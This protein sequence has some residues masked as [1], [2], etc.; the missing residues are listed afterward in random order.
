MRSQAPILALV[1]VVLLGGGFFFLFG[2][3]PQTPIDAGGSREPIAEEPTRDDTS[4]DLVGVQGSNDDLDRA[5][6]DA[7]L[8]ADEV[9]VEGAHPWAGQ[10]A[11]VTGRIVEEDGAP[12]VGMRVE[13]LEIDLSNIMKVEH[14]AMG[15]DAPELGEAFTDEE[16]RFLIDGARRNAYHAFNIGRGT[17]RAT[18]RF[19]ENALEHGELTDVGDIV[20]PAYGT[21]VGTVIDEDGEPVGGARV[22]ALPIP[23]MIVQSGVLD[24]REGSVVAGGEDDDRKMAFD[25]PRR[26]FQLYE[27]LPVPTTYSA[28]DGTFRLE[29]V[30][31]G[32]ISGGADY[33]KHVG[34]P[35]GPIE[36]SAG[37]E[38]DVGELELLFGREVTGKVTDGAGRPVAGVEVAAGALNPLFPA[39]LMQPAGVTDDLGNYSIEGIPEEGRL[40]G[41]ARRTKSESWTVAEG[42]GASD[43]VDI[44][45]PTATPVLVKLRD[46]EGEPI[47]GGK[48]MFE[49]RGGDNDMM[50]GMM[51][52]SMLEGTKPEPAKSR[53]IEPG[54]Y[55][56]ERVTYGEWSIEAEA[57]GYAP[58]YGQVNHTGEGTNA[59]LTMS[60]GNV[61]RVTVTDEA[62]GELVRNAH[63][64]LMAPKGVFVDS[65]AG[66]FTNAEGVTE[67]GPLS[68]TF[69][70]DVQT[71]ESFFGGVSVAVE[72]PRHGTAYVD[73][74]EELAFVEGAIDVAVALPASCTLNGRVSWAGENPPGLY[75]ILLRHVEEDPKLQMTSPPRTALTNH[76]GRFRFTGVAPGKYRATIMERWLEGDP[77]SLII[78][79][80]EPRVLDDRA[81]D[82]EVD[83]ENFLDVQLSPEG[84]GPTGSFAGRVTANG[85]GVPDLKVEVRGLD[86]DLELT[87][88]S[89]GEFETPQISTM[90]R[91][92]IRISGPV[93]MDDGELVDQEV[94]DDWDRPE[95]DQ[96]TR[97]DI[98]LDFQKLEVSVVDKTTGQPVAGA[99]VALRGKGRRSWRGGTDT[100]TNDKGMARVVLPD[101]EERTLQIKKEG[102][103]TLRLEVD[104]NNGGDVLVVELQPA[105]VCK[106]TVILPEGRSSDRAWFRVD[107]GGGR[108]DG[109][110]Q[111][112]SEDLSFEVKGL[113]PGTYQAEMWG[114]PAGGMLKVEFELGQNGDED[115]VLDFSNPM[116]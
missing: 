106:G 34:A 77:I 24:L 41:I 55:E 2:R 112:D 37:E 90:K 27:R 58:A 11:G 1:A 108:G 7:S 45:L 35:F 64:M 66:G 28:A 44:V 87:T 60:R 6:V 110:Q 52:M 4:A 109:W 102:Y 63:A 79:Q 72:H 49:A 15:L 83:A 78:D 70:K 95:A 3:G 16:G 18:I 48:I 10:L 19:I 43:V 14:S 101:D 50:R 54:N 80:K 12:V 100:T 21:L 25:V 71:G 31:P 92:G 57:P 33:P 65:Y 39:G 75:M 56:I 23:E 88:N 26:V 98:D 9:P 76:E 91:V 111:A 89:L 40:M 46:A 8:L 93:P 36:L 84:A 5:A 59:T 62:T 20:L 69:L 22:R 116:R 97:I 103:G 67:L 51:A 85:A 38:H 53:E 32:T 17:G 107:S 68:S 113:M 114:G 61:I 47:T 115:L 81:L 42:S 13:L 29:G 104:G 86:E 30:M 82:V 96:V 94:Y 74:A 99:N 73:V 105:V